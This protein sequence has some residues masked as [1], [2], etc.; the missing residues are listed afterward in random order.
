MFCG[1]LGSEVHN[2]TSGC[3]L[4]VNFDFGSLR[5]FRNRTSTKRK[6]YILRTDLRSTTAQRMRLTLPQAYLSYTSNIPHTS[7]K[8]YLRLRTTLFI[9]LT[10]V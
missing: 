3:W 2:Y 10:D 7:L 1:V 5:S 8:R 6:H 4:S 9:Y